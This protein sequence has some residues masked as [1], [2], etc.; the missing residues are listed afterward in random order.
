MPPSIIFPLEIE[1]MI[2]DFLAEDDE[3]HSAMKISSLVC[4]AFVPICRKH[5]FGSIVLNY[6]DRVKGGFFPTTH[7]FER[8]LH[9]TPEIGD[10][11]RKLHLTIHIADLTSSAPP[12]QESLKRISRLE[13]LSVQNHN[14]QGLGLDWSNNPIRPALLH[15]LHLPT[16]THF[17]VTDI[18]VFTSSDLIPCVNLKYLEISYLAMAAENTF[19]ATFPEHSIQLNEFAVGFGISAAAIM[20]LCSARRP[21]GQPI[22]DVGSLSKISVNIFRLDTSRALQE[23]FRHCQVLTDVSISCK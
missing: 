12:I 8:L 13:F 14:W 10:Y 2:L 15:L 1:E 21:D 18:N 5:I 19:P 20:T 6:D 23:L 7:A 9:E 11:I 16:L 17:A 3:D 22:I 4:R